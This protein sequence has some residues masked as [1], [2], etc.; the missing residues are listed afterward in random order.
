VAR[1]IASA[2]GIREGLI[3]VL[4]CV[5]PCMSYEVYRN[6]EKKLLEL[7][8]RQRKCK[9]TTPDIAREFLGISQLS[10]GEARRRR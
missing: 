3:C 2:D 6:R 10:R 8:P 4:T 7:V 9:F 5:E 1:G